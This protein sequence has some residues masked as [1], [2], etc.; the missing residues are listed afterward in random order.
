[1]LYQRLPLRVSSAVQTSHDGEADSSSAGL[2]QAIN[3]LRLV[4][5]EYRSYGPVR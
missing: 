4:P 1:M 3:G 5:L 2:E